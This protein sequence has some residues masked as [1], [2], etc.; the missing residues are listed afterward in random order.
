[1]KSSRTITLFSVVPD[2]GQQSSSFVVS[3]L[4]HGAAIGLVSLGV[5]Y[6][7]RMNPVLV[8][9]HYTVRHLELHTPEARMRKAGGDGISYPDPHA[10]A[11]TGP[12][13]KTT[14]ET[15]PLQ[16]VSHEA[17]GAQTL[18]QPDIH[19]SATLTREIPVPTIVIWSPEKTAVQSI[20]PPKPE[21]PT[22]ADVQASVDP[23]NEEVNLSDL[24]VSATDLAAQHPVIPADTT[25]PV[26]ARGPEL[27]Q[28]PPVTTSDSTAPATAAAVLSLSELRMP[29]GTVTLPPVNESVSASSHGALL[30]GHAKDASQTGRAD[31]TG[32]GRP[33]NNSGAATDRGGTSGKQAGGQGG[34][35]Q[36]LL[37]GSERGS[38][39]MADH[40]A[41]PRNGQFGSVLVGVSMEEKYP[42]TAAL[43]SSRLAYTVYLHVGLAKNWILQ[44][45]LPRSADAV[46][47]GSI[48]RL[49]APWPYSIVRPNIA[50]GAIDADALMV[51]GFVNQAGRFETL[52]I[53][54]PTEFAQAQF[55]LSS[56][57]Q[58]Q[59]RPASQN[60]QSVKVEILLIIPE[61]LE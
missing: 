49:E 50:A 51:H 3:I 38:R 36:G 15:P 20:V 12:A 26:T 40:I 8:S 14:A 21:Q 18:V 41:L 48:V 54:F 11:A 23:P 45:S 28:L 57:Q 61:E 32:A 4:V 46:N 39:P 6:T 34:P 31:G 44:Y 27:V 5:L 13:G 9:E 42:E 43:W 59:F 10:A 1:M 33:S 58:W 29:E 47:A 22:A 52:T 30:S 19:T 60:G 17:P 25:S 37:S 2:T 24:G 55:V 16:Q 35:A 7:P 56:L 53:A